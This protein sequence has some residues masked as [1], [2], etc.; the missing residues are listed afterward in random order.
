[1]RKRVVHYKGP[2]WW[3][4]PPIWDEQ[5]KLLCQQDDT[6]P[7]ISTSE[8]KMFPFIENIEVDEGK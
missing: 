5:A 8:I 3:N 2:D 1:M 7:S 4:Y 6:K